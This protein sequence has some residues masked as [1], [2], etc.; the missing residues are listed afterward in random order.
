MTDLQLWSLPCLRA[1]PASLPSSLQRLMIRECPLVNLLPPLPLGLLELSLRGC[2]NLTSLPSLPPSLQ[3][4]SCGD[5]PLLTLLPP[6]PRSLVALSCYS[7]PNLMALPH[8][9]PSPSDALTAT[10]QN[11]TPLFCVPMFPPSILHIYCQTALL[12]I[13]YLLSLTWPHTSRASN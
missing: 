7:L 11:G 1:L 4:L 5:S 6:L 12:P 10:L 8:W 3:L 9:L 13:L 2:P